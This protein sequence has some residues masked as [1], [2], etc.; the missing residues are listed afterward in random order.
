MTDPMTI[1]HRYI[2]VWNEIDFAQRRRLMESSWIE[3]ASYVDPMM[4]GTGRE[5]IGTLIGAVHK[6]FPGHRFA[7]QGQPDGYGDRV[8]FSWT[9]AAPGAPAV[10]H[11]TD[12]GVIAEDGRLSTVTGFLDQAPM[13]TVA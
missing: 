12:F 7:L 8:R 10:A 11:G 6:R 4:Q 9:L 1:A 2:E 5:Q 13:G 3:D